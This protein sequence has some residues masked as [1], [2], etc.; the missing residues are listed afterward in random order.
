MRV[1]AIC[2]NCGTIFPS[3]FEFSNSI[4]V[5]FS[6]CGSGPCPSCGRNGHVPDGVYNFIGNTIELLSGPSRSIAELERLALSLK[7]LKVERVSPEQV[8]QIFHDTPELSTLSDALPKTRNELYA[9]I[10]IILSI[11]TIIIGQLKSENKEKIEVNQVINNI[12]QQQAYVNLNQ[13]SLL[14]RP[15]NMT[16]KRRKIG[17]NDMCPCGSGKKY[18]KCCIDK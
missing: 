10:A 4:N 11:I 18:K 9:F 7:R 17:R 5:S 13:D 16:N 12:Y 1:P 15:K 6:N 3:A 2:D 8:A 14:V